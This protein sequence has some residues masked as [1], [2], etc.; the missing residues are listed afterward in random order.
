[1]LELPG[2]YNHICF[3]YS[4]HPVY[5]KSFSGLL[6]GQL[7]QILSSARGIGVFLYVCATL[8]AAVKIVSAEAEAFF[9]L[10]CC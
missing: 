2:V 7:I 6:L 3:I 10:L 1:M 9:S 8:L 4:Q 5:A